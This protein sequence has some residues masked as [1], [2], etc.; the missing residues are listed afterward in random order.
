MGADVARWCVISVV[1]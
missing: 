1:S